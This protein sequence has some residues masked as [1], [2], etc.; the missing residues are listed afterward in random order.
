MEILLNI[1]LQSEARN[2]L[3][4]FFIIQLYIQK[5]PH[6]T[7][8]L[9]CRWQ[10]SIFRYIVDWREERIQSIYSGLNENVEKFLI[11][12]TT[13]NRSISHFTLELLFSSMEQRQ[14][15]WT[16]RSQVPMESY[17]IK[18]RSRKDNS[19]KFI[20]LSLRS[21]YVASHS[22]ERIIVY[23]V[24]DSFSIKRKGVRNCGSNI[25]LK[26]YL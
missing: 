9:G 25:K 17:S 10:K 24:S 4:I 23:T 11:I 22:T 1:C 5:N 3:G 19:I 16:E 26:W 15:M 18:N 7:S 21:L 14:N 2:L 6:K 8:W 13:Y 20:K 12:N